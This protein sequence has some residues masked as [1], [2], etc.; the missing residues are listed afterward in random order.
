MTIKPMKAHKYKASRVKRPGYLQPKLNG[1]RAIWNGTTLN[2]YNEEVWSENILPHIYKALRELP[3]FL[4]DGEIYVHGKSLQWINSRAAVTRKEPHK[5]NFLIQFHI[6]DIAHT[7]SFAER[8]TF[9]ENLPFTY[10]EHFTGKRSALQL[11]PTFTFS[12]EHE[13]NVNFKLCRKLGYEGMIYRDG[14]EGYGFVN[15]CGNKENRWWK[16]MKRKFWEDMDAEIL[17]VV[18]GRGSFENMLGAFLCRGENG[19]MFQVGTGEALTHEMRAKYWNNPPIGRV[20][21]VRYEMLSESG[22]PLKPTVEAVL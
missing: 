18:E 7:A 10:P 8:A 5:E 22:V 17:D 15:K 13:E 6:F 4:Y 16:I 19:S 14:N 20:A 9:L 11:C 21:K 2:T 1:L 3:G 12:S